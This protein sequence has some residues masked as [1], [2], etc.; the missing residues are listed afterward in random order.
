M[1]HIHGTMYNVHNDINK[2]DIHEASHTS[3]YNFELHVLVHNM[4]IHVNF[5]YVVHYPTMM[6]DGTSCVRYSCSTTGTRYS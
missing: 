3:M 5:M 4:Y 2:Y 1:V 6:D